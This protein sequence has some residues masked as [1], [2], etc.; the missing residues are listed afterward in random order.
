MRLLSLLLGSAKKST[1]STWLG[2]KRQVSKPK[3]K[4]TVTFGALTTGFGIAGYSLASAAQ[5]YHFY[6]VVYTD[7][8]IK[9]INHVESSIQGLNLVQE[10]R[11]DPAYREIRIPFNRSRHGFTNNLLAGYGRVTVPP[12][13]FYNKETTQVL[14]VAH[15]GEDV[16]L[17]DGSIHPG[18]LAT[19]MD[20]VLALCSFLGLPN[21]I[22]VTANLSI[23][24]PSKA[25]VN[26]YYVLRSQLEWTKGRKAKVHGSAYMLPEKEG[27]KDSTCVAIADGLF[28][29]P[30]FAKYLKHVIPFQL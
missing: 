4:R 1:A 5:K 27:S 7:E 9:E 17:T 6:P 2:V 19:F 23:S 10:L 20:E 24:N 28:V 13:V 26:R 16:G 30:R 22:G 15:I 25:Y 3:V 18:L 21:N 29:E 11:R 12:L 14:A 8:Q